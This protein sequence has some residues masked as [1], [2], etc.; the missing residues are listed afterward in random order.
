MKSMSAPQPAEK[1]SLRSRVFLPFLMLA[2]FLIFTTTVFL[3]SDL[4]EVASALKVSVGT[5]SQILTVGSLLGLIMGVA[6]GFLA[7]RFK[8]KSLLLLGIASYGA[9]TL[10]FFFAPNYATALLSAVFGGIGSAMAGIMVITM[11]GDFLPL[12]KRGIAVGL[13]LAAGGGVGQLIMPQVTSL[14]TDAAGWRAVLLWFFFPRNR[15]RTRL[16]TSLNTRWLSNKS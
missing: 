6:M 8:H 14:I 7:V 1:R 11:I 12:Q 2:Q 5:A 16:Q 9:G 13:A 10:I 15:G 4:K 3:S